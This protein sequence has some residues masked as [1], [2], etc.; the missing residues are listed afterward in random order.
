MSSPK[1]QRQDQ[2]PKR[3]VRGIPPLRTERARIDWIRAKARFEPGSL[4]LRTK[5][6]GRKE[7]SHD[8]YRV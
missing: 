8:D 6:L 2:E 4:V 7:S 3:R 5:T 1:N